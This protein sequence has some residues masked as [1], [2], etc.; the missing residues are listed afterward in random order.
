MDVDVEVD[1]DVEEDVLKRVAS[2]FN[3]GQLM[4][5]HTPTHNGS[6]CDFLGIY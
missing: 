4:G 5:W 6:F 1:V 3:S 2:R